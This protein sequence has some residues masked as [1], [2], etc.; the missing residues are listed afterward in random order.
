MLPTVM[1][2]VDG[3]ADAPEP[4]LDD[5]TPLQCAAVR[6]LDALARVGRLLR[7]RWDNDLDAGDP[8]RWCALA[9]FDVPYPPARGPLEA[10]ALEVPLAGRDLAFRAPIATGTSESLLGVAPMPAGR[11]LAEI[12]AALE[13]LWSRKWR[14]FADAT[15]AVLRGTDAAGRILHCRTPEDFDGT[16]V[17]ESLP[18]GD[19]AEDLAGIVWD[20]MEILSRLPA[21]R[22]RVDAGA[23]PWL[24]LWP[25]APGTAWVPP[26]RVPPGWS[27]VGSDAS[28]LGLGRGLGMRP[29][30][31]D[32]LGDIEEACRRRAQAVKQRLDRGDAVVWVH[33]R[34]MAADPDRHLAE[35]EAIDRDLVGMVRGE[36]ERCGERV[37]W[38]VAWGDGCP[39]PFLESDPTAEMEGRLPFDGR[40]FEEARREVRPSVLWGK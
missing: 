35:I 17:S 22:R 26:G 33:L 36:L 9:G 38:R 11:E 31:I 10:S 29:V 32:S 27:A 34:R 21:N 8:G 40:G 4:A 14:W 16:S 25:C 39:V 2:V 30:P 37:R 13:P 15:G 23:A 12:I 18:E 19:G 3:P 20:S 6:N 24:C 5:R 7:V 1:L 28:F